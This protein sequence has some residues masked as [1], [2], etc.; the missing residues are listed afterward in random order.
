MRLYKA[1]FAKSPLKVQLNVFYLY[2]TL[3]FPFDIR[4]H[5]I[6]ATIDLYRIRMKCSYDALYEASINQIAKENIL[7]YNHH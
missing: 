5:A 6:W 1:P 3:N 4:V 2:L 7:N